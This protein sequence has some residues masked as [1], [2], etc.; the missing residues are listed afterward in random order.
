LT[1]ETKKRRVVLEPSSADARVDFAEA[2]L[3]AGDAE[4]RRLAEEQLEKALRLV[5]GHK[6]ALVLLV[7][8]LSAD[9]RF[10]RASEL[11]QH[12]LEEGDS[13]PAIYDALAEVHILED[14]L[15]DALLALLTAP[16]TL[17]R[18]RSVLTLAE[19]AKLPWVLTH[20]LREL[21]RLGLAAGELDLA[22]RRVAHVL[23]NHS[24]ET[25]PLS[26]GVEF[27]I[28]RVKKAFRPFAAHAEFQALGVSI[29][30]G[31]MRSAKRDFTLLPEPMRHGAAFL[32]GEILNALLEFAAAER[33][34]ERL[35]QHA[36]LAARAHVRMAELCLH[37]GARAR[38]AETHY[39][40]AMK[41]DASRTDAHEGLG[42]LLLMQ[43]ERT[44][45]IAAY[46]SAIATE[47]GGPCAQK[48]ADLRARRSAGEALGGI[49]ALAYHRFGGALSRIEVVAL[50]GSGELIFTGNIRPTSVEAAKV[51]WSHVRDHASALALT[52]AP[53]THDVH[54]H[55]VDTEIEK[56]GPS[57]GLAIALAMVSALSGTPLRKD[58][59]ATGEL[60][61]TG[62][63]RA[64][65]GLHEKLGAAYLSGVQRVLIPRKNALDTQRLPA[66]VRRNVEIVAV[67]SLAEALL[68]AFEGAP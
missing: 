49:H 58:L 36:E 11:V 54:I 21:A 23:S 38:E 57:A 16:P 46:E 40:S 25:P 26:R 27:L 52:K 9:R 33:V 62:M 13:D 10:A 4:K 68:L 53:K 15:Q 45:A 1:L 18:T 61:L 31:D 17:E 63:V 28:G 50:E 39:R 6:N 48:L 41:L 24:A 19:K 42:D 22:R 66:L 8:L 65:G 44:L 55:Y 30:A 2:L 34:F 14:R 35:E 3:Q 64:I 47:P 5:P 56:D 12:C 37:S 67:E 43:G 7:S 32:K 59:A 51:V 20:A 60:T 29:R